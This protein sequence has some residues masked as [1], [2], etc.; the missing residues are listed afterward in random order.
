MDFARKTGYGQLE[1][2]INTLLYKSAVQ[3]ET[4]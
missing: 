2:M 1:D 3:E 4:E